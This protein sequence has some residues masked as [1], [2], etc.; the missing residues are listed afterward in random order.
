MLHRFPTFRDDSS[1]ACFKMSSIT[2]QNRFMTEKLEKGIRRIFAL[3]R[4][5]SAQRRAQATKW[6]TPLLLG[7]QLIITT[8]P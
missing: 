7:C 8:K 2:S 5:F 3:P 1:L 6:A 4:L